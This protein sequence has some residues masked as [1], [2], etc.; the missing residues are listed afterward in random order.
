[1]IKETTF[2]GGSPDGP[3]KEW[4]ENGEVMKI[5]EYRDNV[6][7]AAPATGAPDSTQLDGCVSGHIDKFHSTNGEDAP[8]TNEQLGKWEKWCT[9][10]QP[11]N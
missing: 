6:F 2:K 5:G 1:L 10:G 7:Y 4:F 3:T 8:V 11:S 9:Q